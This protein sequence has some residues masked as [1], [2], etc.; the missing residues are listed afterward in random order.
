MHGREP[1]L[2]EVLNRQTGALEVEQ[3]LVFFACRGIRQVD[4]GDS[5][6]SLEEGFPLLYLAFP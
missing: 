2:G 5:L 3:D 1:A 6:R 4:P